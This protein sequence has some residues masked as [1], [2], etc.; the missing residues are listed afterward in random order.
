[1]KF[2]SEEIRTKAVQAFLGG[3]ASAKKLA[4]IFGYTPGTIGNWVRAYRR[5]NQ[6][7]PKPNAHRKKCFSDEELEELKQLL[8]KNVDMTL[9]EIKT[10]FNKTC[11]LSAIHRMLIKLGYKYKKNSKGKR[12]GTRRCTKEA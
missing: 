2:A 10:H 6:L 3:K 8:D 9:E 12:T 5:H 4:E 1:M 11:C 7:A